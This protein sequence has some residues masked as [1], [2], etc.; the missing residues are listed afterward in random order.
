MPVEIAQQLEVFLQL[1]RYELDSR[2]IPRFESVHRD[3]VGAQDGAGAGNGATVR[4]GRRIAEE[5]EDAAL[6]RRREAVLEMM[7]FIVRF[8][9]AQPKDIVQEPLREAVSPRDLLCQVASS[10]RQVD[11]LLDVDADKAI[12]RHAP[13]SCPRGRRSYAP[14]VSGHADSVTLTRT[15]SDY[16]AL[17]ISRG[18]GSRLRP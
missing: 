9:P 16:G 8:R 14:P 11:R 6:D 1:L 15:R 7:R 4:T 10:L 3:Q 17:E 12:A 18:P 13:N 2:A 5:G